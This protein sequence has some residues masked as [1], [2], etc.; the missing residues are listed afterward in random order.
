MTVTTNTPAGQVGASIS[1]Q[2]P[3]PAIESN[4]IL[5]IAQAALTK[6]LRQNASTLLHRKRTFYV[7]ANKSGAQ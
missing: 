2:K 6:S 3:Q 4:A 5:D 7:C 1:T